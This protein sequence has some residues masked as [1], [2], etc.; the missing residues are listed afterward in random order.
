MALAPQKF[1]EIV[2]QLIYSDDFGSDANM[3]EMLM[4]QLA[5]TRQ[6]VRKAYAYREKFLEKKELIDALIAEYSEEYAFDRIPRI[7]RNVIRLGLYELFFSEEIPPKVAIAE[8]IRLARKF[9][10]AES[11][12]FVNAVL[13]SIYK[14]KNL[15]GST[16]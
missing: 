16:V 12:H 3:E 1:R 2:F 13:D 6:S 8:A 5:V 14:A 10:T 11:A 9:A 4:G 7:E 15:H